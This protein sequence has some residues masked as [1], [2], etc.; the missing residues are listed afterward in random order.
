MV[1][2]ASVRARVMMIKKAR[3]SAGVPLATSAFPAPAEGLQRKFCKRIFRDTSNPLRNRAS[4]FLEAARVGSR[5][6][7][8]CRNAQNWAF[9]GWKADEIEKEIENNPEWSERYL[10]IVFLWEE[11]TNDPTGAL[12][13]RDRH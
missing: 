6:C 10:L 4:P 12:A 3:E 5:V 7:V 13:A 2:M 8:P 1:S 11:K 9:K